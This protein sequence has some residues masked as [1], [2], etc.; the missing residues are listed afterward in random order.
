M[1]L[2]DSLMQLADDP[3]SELMDRTEFMSRF[4][5][6]VQS[7]LN[8]TGPYEM[9]IYDEKEAEISHMHTFDFAGYGT[10]PKL[11]ES[12]QEPNTPI[13]HE[14]GI[15]QF[16]RKCV[17]K[18]QFDAV[19]KAAPGN[20]P[21]K[22]GM[23]QLHRELESALCKVKYAQFGMKH[24]PKA[25]EA[26]LMDFGLQT[27]PDWVAPP[28]GIPDEPGGGHGGGFF[29]HSMSVKSGAG[30]PIPEGCLDNDPDEWE[31]GQSRLGGVDM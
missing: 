21:Y 16:Y 26:K 22:L 23:D 8:R 10:E 19:Y 6:H 2:D 13:V 29:D 30:L 28:E 3:N 9:P 27:A 18:L 1:Q 7:Y 4:N 25:F 17:A 14:A 5:W 31:N 24:S 12:G 20:E 15:L 11:S